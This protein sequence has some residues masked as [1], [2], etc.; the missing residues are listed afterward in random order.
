VSSLSAEPPADPLPLVAAWLE[1]ANDGR[2]NPHAMALATSDAGARPSVR[3]V[4]LKQLSVG[5]GYVVFYTSYCSRK[6]TELR[7]THRAAAALYWENLGRQMRFEGAVVRSPTAE[8]DLYFS[9]RPWR[10]Q[11]NAWSS[12]QSQPLTDLA[13]LT[14]RSVERARELGVDPERGPTS[15]PLPRPDF[16]GGFRLWLDC[17]EF[18]V[19]GV[20]RFHERVRYTRSLEPINAYS[21]SGGPWAHQRLQP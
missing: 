7:S 18:W 13:E 6:A 15:R 5:D 8:S 1:A 20:D 3:M 17:V 10:S 21:F 14:A 2:R 11:L 16:W 9:T 19:E 12:E 4:L